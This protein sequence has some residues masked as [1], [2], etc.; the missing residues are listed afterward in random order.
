MRGSALIVSCG[1]SCGGLITEHVSGDG[2]ISAEQAQ[3]KRAVVDACD[4]GELQTY[5]DSG[6][7]TAYLSLGA[8]AADPASI[9]SIANTVL[10]QGYGIL[11]IFGNDSSGGT[12]FTPEQ[13]ATWY[14]SALQ[15]EYP[16]SPN[17]KV[18][19]QPPQ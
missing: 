12:G 6:I 13:R 10:K 8:T 7:A 17:A 5:Q 4:C 9:S 19:Y 3:V 15:G 2:S 18:V 1:V 16:A 11:M 14:T